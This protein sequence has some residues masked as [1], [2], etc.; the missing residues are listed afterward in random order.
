MAAGA[1]SLCA[2]FLLYHISGYFV[3]RKNIQILNKNNPEIC[4]KLPIALHV[5]LW[6]YNYRKRDTQH[7]IKNK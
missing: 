7:K 3:N 2:G 4:V 5:I 1:R 6:Y